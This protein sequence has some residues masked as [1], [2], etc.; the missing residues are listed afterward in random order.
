MGLGLHKAKQS[1]GDCDLFE[2]GCSPWIGIGLGL[3]A[4]GEDSQPVI[5][6]END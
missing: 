4:G 3:G 6:K 2:A 1:G 5:E